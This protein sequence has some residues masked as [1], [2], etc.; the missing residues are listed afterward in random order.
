MTGKIIVP[1]DIDYAPLD[2]FEDQV[3]LEILESWLRNSKIQLQSVSE[4]TR[5]H[6]QHYVRNL[7]HSGPSYQLLLL[8][9]KNGQRSPIHDHIGSNCAVKV[10]QGIATESIFE[11]SPNGLYYPTISESRSPGQ[12]CTLADSDVHQMSNLQ[13][14]A[15]DLITLHIYSPPLLN[16]NAYSLTEDTISPFFD[17]VNEEFVSGGGI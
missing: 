9:W 11:K 3:P 14:D 13:P 12:I 8:C 17:P 6:P 2:Q 7:I 4:Y 5:F 15:A 16:M 1:I 10:L